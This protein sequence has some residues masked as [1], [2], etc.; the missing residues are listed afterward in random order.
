LLD[1]GEPYGP[2]L[3]IKH[4]GELFSGQLLHI[5]EN[6]EN[7][8]RRSLGEKTLGFGRVTARPSFSGR[9]NPWCKPALR[10]QLTIRRE[11][12]QIE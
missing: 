12:L 6:Q 2:H 4:R 9:K 10:L 5:V 8:Q 1:E 11:R 7:P 3:K